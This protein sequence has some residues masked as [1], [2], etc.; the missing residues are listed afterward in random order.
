MDIQFNQIKSFYDG[1]AGLI[2]GLS[3]QIGLPRIIDNH[4]EKHT[5]RPAEI[6]Y[7]SLAQ[8]ML[9]NIS[10]DHHPLSRLMT[11]FENVD[12]ESLLGHEIDLKKLND[13]RFG[14]FLDAMHDAGCHKIYAELAANAFSRYGI[15]LKNVNFDTTSKVMWGAY[16]T[17]EGVEG[18]VD[19]TFGYSKQKRPDKRQI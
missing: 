12:I 11:Y 1:K 10:D 16:E 2:C 3:Q 6:P 5:G 15:A 8:L 7:G 19:I 13:D 9:I 18:A 14:G 17:S 4:L